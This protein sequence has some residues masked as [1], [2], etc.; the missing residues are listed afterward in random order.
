M[1]R[2]GRGLDRH[3]GSTYDEVKGLFEGGEILLAGSEQAS[4]RLFTGGGKG[5][6]EEKKKR[7]KEERK[8]PSRKAFAL[9]R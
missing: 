1:R 8:K 9:E 5:M 6:A 2:R 4:L 7:K 3:G